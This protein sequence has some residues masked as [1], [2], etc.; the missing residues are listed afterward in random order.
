MRPSAAIQT[1]YDNSKKM[2]ILI[3]RRLLTLS[4]VAFAAMR[5]ALAV[6]IFGIED[7][8][9]RPVPSGVEEVLRMYLKHTDYKECAD[10]KFVGSAVDLK[11]NGQKLDWIAKTADGCAWGAN[12][13]KIW[14]LKNEKNRYR[15]VLYDGGQGVVLLNTKTHGLRD[16]RMPSGTAGHYSD[17]LLK[18]DGRRYKMFRFCFI[19]LLDPEENKRHPD[20]RCHVN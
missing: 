15:I 4:L 12:T 11:G 3:K 19:D 7:D 18:F 1:S 8:N 5:P 14:I 6:D 17:K 20:G 2:W 13:A 9:L 10:G 16:L